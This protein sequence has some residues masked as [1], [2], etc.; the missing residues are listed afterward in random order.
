MAAVL[1]LLP[2]RRGRRAVAPQPEPRDVLRLFPDGYKGRHFIYALAFEGDVVKVG[3]T[4]S[5]RRRLGQHWDSVNGEVRWI[6]LFESMH[7]ETARLVEAR[8]PEALKSIAQ[9][10]NG[11]EWFFASASKAEVVAVLRP[12]VVQAKAE[13][14]ARWAAEEA[15]KKRA[16]AMYRVL[17]QHG[18]VP[19]LGGA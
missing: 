3:Q 17:E 10:I 13:T 11:S 9:Q 7:S 8:A 6:H 1:S 14:W 15:R 4:H 19:L 5:P 12:V 16:E 18:L 2:K